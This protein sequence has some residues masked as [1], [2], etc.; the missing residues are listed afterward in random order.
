MVLWHVV[1]SRLTW[2]GSG[3]AEAKAVVWLSILPWERE[4]PNVLIESRA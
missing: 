4:F 2:I 3:C 1:L